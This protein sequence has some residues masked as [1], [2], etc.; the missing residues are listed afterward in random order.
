VVR[1]QFC[2]QRLKL[3]VSDEALAGALI[4]VRDEEFGDG[5]DREKGSVANTERPECLHSFL[6]V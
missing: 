3:L 4:L 2:V 1:R 5:G 6:R